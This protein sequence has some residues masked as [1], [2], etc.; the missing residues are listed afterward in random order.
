MFDSHLNSKIIL[1]GGALL[2]GIA[3]QPLS[4]AQENEVQERGVEA[5]S[6]RAVK[7]ASAPVLDG[8]LDDEVWQQ[9][10][11]II[12]FHQSRPGDHAEPSEETELYVVYTEDALY[13]AARMY[14]SNPE[15][16]SAPTI[17][18]GQGLPFDDRLVIILDPFNQGRAGYRFET[19]L[20]GVRHDSLY[21]TPTA[22]RLD[23]NTIWE[24]ATSIDGKS[25]VA[26][27]EIPFKSLPFDPRLDTWGF[28]FGRGIRRR[29]EEMSWVSLDRTYNPTIM[30][31][32][33]GLEGMNQGLGLDI[34]PSFT[35]LR[36][37][38]FS[39]N[40]SDNSLEPSLDAFYRLT[41]SLNAALTVNTDFSAAE[42]D[43]RQVNLTRFNLF[44]PEKR[45]FF[46]NDS[47]LFQFGDISRMAAGNNATGGAGRENARPY[48][49][50][51][52]GLAAD[53]SPVD[54]EYGGR[55]SGRVGRFNIGTLAIR[56]GESE[57]VAAADMLVTRISANVLEDS[58]VGFIYTNGDPTSNVDNSVMGADF[59]Y[60]NNNLG[61][62]RRLQSN[63]F[64][65]QSDT[66]GL[67][68]DDASYGF[69]LAL[70]ASE[71]LRTRVG[72]KVV[73]DNFN[74]AM[75]FV[76]RSNIEDIT[77]DFGYT[78]FF[79][80]G[81][82]QTAFA[83]IDMQRV[84]V[85][86]GGLQSEVVAFRLLELES[87]TRDSIRLSYVS[88]KEVV[89]APFRIYRDPSR[90]VVIQPGSYDFDEQEF[91]I[92]SGGQ[93]EFSG[94]FSYRTGDFYN[95]TRKNVN[96]SFTWNQSRYFTAT[97]RSDWN[98]IVLPQGSFITRLTSANSQI[99]FSPTL[100]WI[101]LVQY[102]NL[103]EEIGINTRLQWIPKAGQEAFIVLNHN[104][105]DWD[106]DNT[107]HS[108][109]SDLSVKFRY[110]FRF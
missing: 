45:D 101:S 73:E 27:V 48:F 9:A 99:A 38:S 63:V 66:P 43:N 87:N 80:D 1:L 93:R 35:G 10:E 105:Q 17:R 33:T 92:S 8:K 44:F 22:F 55:V 77:A 37:R 5:K 78:H 71:G 15:L 14:D 83:G 39:P 49:S 30:G 42:V 107:F 56:Q 64:F 3:L 108:A 85:I 74:P 94:S 106:R 88:N 100:Y 26:E 40:A 31:E 28:N 69:G 12:D 67:V 70:P 29:N 32:M 21:E 18:H 68:G 86:D 109:R 20:N 59:M 53:G 90:E 46:L 23:W 7:V 54:I 25:W 62:G 110:T 16:I 4:V 98:D 57:N 81:L 104:M 19:N 52:L 89:R 84:N 75:G 95:G 47:D 36:Q 60:V 41:P 24:T 96:A 91:G 34:V 79:E 97:I 103:S 65:Q 72:Y 58:R 102:D 2:G 13:V 76:S 51:K 61:A 50:R 82:F 6:F 11:R